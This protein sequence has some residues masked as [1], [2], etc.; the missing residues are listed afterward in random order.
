M[1]IQTRSSYS[2][3]FLVLTVLFIV[4]LIIS[5]L[6]EIKTVP[7]GPFTIT[8][9]LVVF[10]IS[11][12]INDCIVEIYGFKAARLAIWLGFAMMLLVAL[13]LNVAI[14]LPSTPDWTLQDAMAAIF[15]VV[16]RMM[17]AS[18]AAFLC[19][20]MANAYVMHRM[21]LTAKTSGRDGTMR[22]SIRAIVSTLWGESI[23]SLVF[24]PIAFGGMLP[25]EVILQ[26]I[27]SQT[28]LK[29]AYEIVILPA[30]ITVVRRLRHIEL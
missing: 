2:L 27:I 13:L 3:P 22:F 8:A 19:G 17:F 12:I 26:L 29:T 10:P 23:D 18:F 1:T 16:P 6:V 14:L 7:L 25:P 20:S 15:G 9:G 28:L 11:Y 24:F 21:K 4:C 30:T 5:N